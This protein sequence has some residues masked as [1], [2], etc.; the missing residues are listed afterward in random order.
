MFPVTNI[1]VIF[2]NEMSFSITDTNIEKN[3]IKKKK[4]LTI[5]PHFYIRIYLFD[6]FLITLCQS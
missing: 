4:R 3:L 2:I 1:I 6:T 5:C